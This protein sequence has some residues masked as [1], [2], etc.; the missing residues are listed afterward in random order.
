MKHAVSVKNMFNQDINFSHSSHST[1]D[2]VA[3]A[4]KASRIFV[5]KF[6]ETFEKIQEM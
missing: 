2:A 3:N 4:L 6:H 1:S 5:Q